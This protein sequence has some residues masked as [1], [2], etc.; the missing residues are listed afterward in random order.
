[1]L[2]NNFCIRPFTSVVIE[3]EGEYKVCCKIKNNKTNKNIKSNYNAKDTSINEWWNSEYLHKLRKQFLNGEK[4]NECYRCW[5]DESKGIKSHR[6][7]TNREYKVLWTTNEHKKYLTI[8]NY[9]DLENPIDYSIHASNLCNLKCIMCSGRFSSKL[10]TENHNLGYELELKQK[11]YQWTNEEQIEILNEVY[12]NNIKWINLMG[13]EPL[14]N[15]NIITFLEKLVD[16]NKSKSISLHLTTNT[17]TCN[18]KILNLLK[19]FKK[20]RIVMSIDG[21]EKCNDY[22]RYPSNWKYI[23][24]NVN[25]FKTLK[26]VNLNINCVVQNLNILH[27]SKI[28]NYAN[29]KKIYIRFSLLDSPNY[30]HISNLPKNVLKKC[31]KNI[32]SI[33]KKQLIHSENFLEIK[34]ILKKSIATYKKNKD[35]YETF[36]NTIIKRDNYRKINIKD[37]IPELAK[38]IYK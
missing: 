29:E 13:G 20:V 11:N 23:N 35:L 9:N 34:E 33:D 4:P 30:L 38:E 10:M 28:L 17:T 15:S 37:Y 24:E 5:Q 16:N 1:M 14:I 6:I 25:Q 27:L 26:N 3:P 19:K 21:I 18:Q 8:L 2:K 7:L 22:L 12:S 32:E 31:L 36:I